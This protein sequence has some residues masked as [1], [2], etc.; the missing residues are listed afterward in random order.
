MISPPHKRQGGGLAIESKTPD[1][2][3]VVLTYMRPGST[4]L[5]VWCVS[6]AQPSTACDAGKLI[7]SREHHW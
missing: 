4:A 7:D 6:P 5:P 1:D 2:T 3:K